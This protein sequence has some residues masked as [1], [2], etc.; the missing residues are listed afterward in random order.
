MSKWFCFEA[1]FIYALI[2]LKVGGAISRSL[3][4]AHFSISAYFLTVQTYKRMR[5][6]IRVYGIWF[7]IITTLINN[8]IY[9]SSKNLALLIIQHPLS[10]IVPNN[11][12][13]VVTRIWYT[14]IGIE[15]ARGWNVC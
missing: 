12:A 14:Y 9:H 15:C 3:I 11:S 5:L 6:T 13:K 1:A 2:T 7:A 8:S 10:K 4:S